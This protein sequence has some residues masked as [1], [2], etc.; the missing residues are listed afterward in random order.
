MPRLPLLFLILTPEKRIK[1][2]SFKHYLTSFY[3]MITAEL[4]KYKCHLQKAQTEASLLSKSQT[5]PEGVRVCT[6]PVPWLYPSYAS[7]VGT[8]GH[9]G[10]HFSCA[11]IWTSWA[12]GLYHRSRIYSL[13]TQFFFPSL[14]LDRLQSLQWQCKWTW[15]KVVFYVSWSLICFPLKAAAHSRKHKL[16]PAC[17]QIP[18][19]NLTGNLDLHLWNSAFVLACLSFTLNFKFVSEA[20][21]RPHASD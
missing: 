9:A 6:L 20:W 3:A 10:C 14:V 2:S 19:L 13:S 1:D 8:V 5:W 12:Q 18:P 16:L 15:F 7:T 4:K 11:V 21:C 17:L